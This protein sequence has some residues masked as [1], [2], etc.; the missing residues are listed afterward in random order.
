VNSLSSASALLAALFLAF[1]SVIFLI[2]KE[3][4][5]KIKLPIDTERETKFLQCFCLTSA[6][7]AEDD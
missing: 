4:V 5:P 6:N 3:F 7:Y 1:W 2:F